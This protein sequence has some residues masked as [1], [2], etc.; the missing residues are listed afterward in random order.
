M[1]KTVMAYSQTAVSWSQPT[2]DEV[3]GRWTKTLGP[4]Q[5]CTLLALVGLTLRR[6]YGAVEVSSEGLA[7]G[8]SSREIGYFCGLGMSVRSVKTHIESLCSGD[9]INVFHRNGG[10]NSREGV[11]NI[12]EVNL[13][14]VFSSYEL[15][16]AAEGNVCKFCTGTHDYIHRYFVPS[17]FSSGLDKSNLLSAG[18]AAPTVA[19][20]EINFKGTEHMLATPK[21]VRV[22]PTRSDTIVGAMVAAG[23]KRKETQDARVAQAF[24]QPV[25]TK[26]SLQA[27]LDKCMRDYLPNHPRVIVTDKP[28]SVLKKRIKDAEVKDPAAFI[29]WTI[30]SWTTL[31]AQNK[32]TF[33]R[34]H[35]QTGRGSPLPESPGFIALA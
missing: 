5:T 22:T 29:R 35:R 8:V 20:N 3:F 11:T 33:L 26:A 17:L 24:T 10:K 15:V 1:L 2:I 23:A 28:L 16:P 7:N 27:L 18:F 19:T 14:K 6:G 25:L 13:K 30:R 32:A 12:L 31:A 4:A 9:F 34:N 21:R